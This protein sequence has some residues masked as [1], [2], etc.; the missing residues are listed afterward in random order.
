MSA[1]KVLVLV[2]VLAANLD[3]SLVSGKCP[4]T[5]IFDSF[6]ASQVTYAQPYGN[7]LNRRY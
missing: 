1:V 5:P 4:K 6:N 2:V 7:E 3:K